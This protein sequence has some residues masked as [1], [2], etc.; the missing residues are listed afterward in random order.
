MIDIAKH[1]RKIAHVQFRP[2]R[3]GIQM[4]SLED[5][6]S[7]HG[8]FKTMIGMVIVIL[9]GGPAYSCPIPLLIRVVTGF[10]EAV[11]PREDG[12]PVAAFKG[13][14]ASARR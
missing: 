10:I 11:V 9:A 5:G 4:A 7:W 6:S 3:D 12:H 14:P 1:S 13:I 8:G 2:G